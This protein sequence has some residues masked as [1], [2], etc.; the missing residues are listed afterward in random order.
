[1]YIQALM[2]CL[3][4]LTVPTRASTGDTSLLINRCLEMVLLMQPS[5]RDESLSYRCSLKLKP[6]AVNILRETLLYDRGPYK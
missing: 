1:M 5:L 6:R 3:R 4:R 2:R